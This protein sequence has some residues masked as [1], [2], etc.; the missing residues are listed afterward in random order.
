MAS[1][2][3]ARP[4]DDWFFAGLASSF[5]NITDSSEQYFKLSWPQLCSSPSPS[6]SSPEPSTKVPGCKVFH[7]KFTTGEAAP[8]STSPTTTTTTVEEID[9]DAAV[10]ED[11]WLMREQVLVFQYRGTFH[12]VDHACPHRAYSLSWGQPFD[13]EDAGRVVGRGIRCRG[14]GYAFELSTG[15]G[16][17]GEYR[18]GVWQVEL[19][20]CG[21]DA[22]EGKGEEVLGVVQREREREREVWVRRRR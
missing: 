5:P 17:R 18:L 9:I 19:R 1:S 4:G 8:G 6:S 11:A 21:E 2:S 10:G 14:H 22:G 20:G 15:A 16:D 7:P 13:I 3:T 12:A